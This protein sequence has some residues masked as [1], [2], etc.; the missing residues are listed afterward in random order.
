MVFFLFLFRGDKE[1]TYAIREGSPTLLGLLD[2]GML[3]V[4]LGL[5]DSSVVA[6]VG[7]ELVDSGAAV[8]VDFLE[9]FPLGDSGVAPVGFFIITKLGKYFIKETNLKKQTA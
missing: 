5:L 2:C 8:L 1:C 4:L 7:V 6:I 3:V 9:T